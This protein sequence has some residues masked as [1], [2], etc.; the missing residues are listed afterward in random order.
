MRDTIQRL[1]E[2]IGRYYY[3]P[4]VQQMNLDEFASVEHY[5]KN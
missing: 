3:K 1:H 5:L 4:L 2:E